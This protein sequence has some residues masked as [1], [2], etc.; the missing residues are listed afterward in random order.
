[1]RFLGFFAKI[2]RTVPSA[3]ASW[4]KEAL[5]DEEERVRAT[6]PLTADP[7]TVAANDPGPGTAGRPTP[8][9]VGA[10]SSLSACKEQ[11]AVQG[12]ESRL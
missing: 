4:H 9:E 1:M 11:S 10:D 7:N 6:V 2:N 12:A 5:R 8:P 3:F